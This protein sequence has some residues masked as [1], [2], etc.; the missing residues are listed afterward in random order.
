MSKDNIIGIWTCWEPNAFDGRDSEYAGT[1]YNDSTGRFIPYVYKDGNSYGIE[2]LTGYDVSGDGDYY[3]GARNSGKPYITDPFEYNV[4]GKKTSLYSIAIPVMK[5][6]AVAGVVGIDISIDNIIAVINEGSILDVGYMFVLSPNGLFT[7]HRNSDLLL[8][9]YTTTWIK[10]FSS[11]INSLLSNGG[12][13][14]VTSFSDQLNTDVRFLATGIKIG[15]TDRYWAV[16]GVVPDKTATESAT[17]LVWLVIGIGL[18]LIL[19]VS[20]ALLILITMRLRQLPVMTGTAESIAK[21]DINLANMDT[22][23]WKTKN[24]ITLLERAF[25]TMTNSIKAQA[26]TMEKIAQGDYSVDIPVRCETDVM[27][28]AI[29]K[30]IDRTNDTM[31][32]I[33]AS[34]AQ[35]STGSKQIA[36]GSQ[37]LAQGS[38]QQ[39]AAVEQLSSSI[40]EIAQKTKDNADMADR[41]AKLADAIKNS[42]EK[43]SRQMGEMMEAVKE[44]NQASQDIN[45]VIKVIDDIA[46]QTNILALNAAVEAA[47]AGQ[48]GKGFAVV[49]DEVRNLAAKSADA[50][51]DTGGLISNSIEKAELG[52]RIADETAASLVEI[53]NGINESNQLVGEIARS[54]NEQSDGISQVNKGIDQVAQVVQQNS[55][56]AE[57]S[58][59]ASEEMSGQAILLENLIEQFKL[60]EGGGMSRSL[61]S[62]SSKPQRKQLVMPE[63]TS[64]AP[65]ADNGDFGKY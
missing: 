33:R 65:I 15:A 5:N 40:S 16:C 62:S 47:R 32:E 60:K 44:I 27:N 51:K 53:V 11:D 34:T 8:T 59:A 4:G 31:N 22:G 28:K 2:A 9:S 19:V 13:F 35:V 3:L 46:F 41:A 48:H 7:S 57:E 61:P 6:G 26:E 58:A 45:K 64:Y 30:M 50:A 56:T 21:G 12:S 29:N 23:T 17:S 54:S 39:A 1:E 37:A 63:K 38:T 43:G 55:A 10:G 25:S 18:A 36:D 24:E 14:E 20:V 42:A 49:A 52:A